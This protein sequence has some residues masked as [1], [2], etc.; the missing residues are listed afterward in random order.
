MSYKYLASPYSSHCKMVKQQ[1]FERICEIAGLLMK[2]GHH[3]FVPI[4][5]S[6]PIQEFGG[7]LGTWEYWEK[8]DTE[9]VLGASELWVVTMP[10]W[11][12]S[13]GVLAEIKI[14]ESAGIPIKYVNP[15]TLKITSKVIAHIG[16][17][18]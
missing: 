3:L 12:Q 7:T 6:H 8:F 11:D 5:M 15:D 4:A 14:A 2:Q 18:C 17:C 1:R 9:F 16:P 10:N 13:V